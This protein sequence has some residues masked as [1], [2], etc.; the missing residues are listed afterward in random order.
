MKILSLLIA[1]NLSISIAGA[2][3]LTPASEQLV[4]DLKVN[5]DCYW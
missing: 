5:P 1:F 2:A 4:D 3:D